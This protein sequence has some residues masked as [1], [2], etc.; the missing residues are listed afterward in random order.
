M[1]FGSVVDWLLGIDFRSAVGSLRVFGLVYGWLLGVDFRSGVEFLRPL[2]L[3][4][5]ISECS[6]NSLTNWVIRKDITHFAVP[7]L[8]LILR[9]V[10]R[11]LGQ[12]S[13]L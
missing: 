7:L 2:Q 13:N 1:V 11:L 3:L 5:Q 8:G 10:L 12:L 9:L 4:L 6:L